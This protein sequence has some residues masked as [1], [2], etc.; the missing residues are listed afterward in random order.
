MRPRVF[1]ASYYNRELIAPSLDRL[2]EQAEVIVPPYQGRNLTEDELIRSLTG[3]D[4]VIAADEPYTERALASTERLKIIARDGE[5]INS[6]DLPAATQ[7]GIMVVNAPVVS[8]AAANLTL[9]LILCLVRKIVVGDRAVRDGNFSARENLLCPDLEDKT[10]GIVG[11]GK[12]GRAMV[13]RVHSLS[14]RALV[15]TGSASRDAARE[16]GVEVLDLEPL[17]SRSDIVTLHVPLTSETHHLIGSRQ[18]AMMK[19]GSYLVN[20]SRGSVLDEK[21]LVAALQSG[22][23]AGAALDVYETEPP[24]PD[25]PLFRMHNVVLTPHIGGDTSDTMVRAMQTVVRNILEW[26][27]G[28][29]PPNLRNPGSWDMDLQFKEARCQPRVRQP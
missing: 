4:A 3:I 17:L 9:G 21:A 7:R 24:A 12:I 23:L 2:R 28:N 1:L 18:L 25:N 22:H 5:G 20:A 8:E 27:H 14:M 26:M 13:K 6:I 19:K 10:I 11:F 16:L 29:R 15:T